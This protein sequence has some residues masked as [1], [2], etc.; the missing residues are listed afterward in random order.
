MR[1]LSHSAVTTYLDCPQRWKLKYVDK[2]PEKPRHFFSFGKTLH[3]ALEFL[4]GVPTPPP[5]SLADLLEYY[6]KN[7][8]TEGY[9]SPD[10]EAKYRA[11]GRS[12]LEAYYAKNVP[13]FRVPFFVEYKFETQVEIPGQ[14][15]FVL[16]IGGR[17]QE[18]SLEPEFLTP[19]PLL[20]YVDRIDKTE[21]GRLEI[22]DYKTGKAFDLDRVREDPQLS[23]YQMVCEEKLGM[24]VA[25]LT[26][27]HLPSQTPFTVDRRGEALVRAVRERV[28]GVGGLVR[29]GLQKLDEAS[30]VLPAEFEPKPEERKCSWCDF[31]PFCPAWR[32]AYA[33]P[34][35]A[36]DEAP[37]LKSDRQIEKLV[38]R[39]GQ[40]HDRMA[41]LEEESEA[42]KK[43]IVAQLKSHGY[44]RAFG[45][46][47]EVAMHSEEKWE[48]QDKDKQKIR[49]AIQRAGFWDRIIAPSAPLVQKLM[50][51]PALPLDLQERLRK[52][53]KKVEH[54]TLRLKKIAETE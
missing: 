10:Q 22:V 33:K 40:L 51:D 28:V 3:S 15:T 32:Q 7:W 37:V 41:A 14:K 36:A 11:E 31:K 30:D 43:D 19:V 4:Y 49:D 20:G 5:P 27:Y 50:N 52:L 16:P 2:L 9:T 48:I 44:V 1:P 24:K 8:L 29:R 13:G 18:I 42:L 12:I 46:G 54:H 25:G 47:Y 6:R 53:A 23:L 21:D 26:L 45:V 39:Y 17:P 34:V 35:P 38:D